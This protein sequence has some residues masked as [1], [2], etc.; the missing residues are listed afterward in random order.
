M[1]WAVALKFL[2]GAWAFI[3]GIPWWAWAVA[4]VLWAWHIDRGNQYEA[5]VAWERDRQ[6]AA[7][8]AADAA[9]E[10]QERQRDRA[11]QDAATAARARAAE[12]TA[13]TREKTATT[14]ERIRY[15][16]RTVHVPADCDQPLPGR[17]QDDIARAIEAANAAGG[18]LPAGPDQ[19]GPARPD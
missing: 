11:S 1:T 9:L 17:V 6:E 2:K 7:Q 8:R 14:V 12:A 5:G 3:R 10:Q 13:A 16:I 19:G 4:A 18:R 15:E